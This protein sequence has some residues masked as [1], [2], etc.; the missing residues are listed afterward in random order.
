MQ[1]SHFT[2]L[3]ISFKI[4]QLKLSYVKNIFFDTNKYK[5]NIKHQFLFSIKYIH[6]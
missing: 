4:F 3:I 6:T 5:F 2:F 1:K